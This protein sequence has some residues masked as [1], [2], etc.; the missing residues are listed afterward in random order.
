MVNY[1]RFYSNFLQLVKDKV[2][3]HLSNGHL[4]EHILTIDS[5]VMISLSNIL[6]ILREISYKHRKDLFTFL[7]M[8]L[9]LIRIED[10]TM[11]RL[12]KF[13]TKDHCI[14]SEIERNYKLLLIFH[15]HLNY[16][17]K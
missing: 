10:F 3:F 5:Y 9:L 8:V 6:T 15:H 11:Y 4:P 7:D 13:L 16:L 2:N 14:H 12:N 1:L 17:I